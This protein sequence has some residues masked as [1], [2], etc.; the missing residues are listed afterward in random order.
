MTTEQHNNEQIYNTIQYNP[1]ANNNE[2]GMK[3]EQHNNDQ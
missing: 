1:K 2:K 3:T